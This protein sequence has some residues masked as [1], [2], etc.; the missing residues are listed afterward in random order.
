MPIPAAIAFCLLVAAF[1]PAS[2]AAGDRALPL[3]RVADIRR[4]SHGEAAKAL[5]VKVSGVCFWR[6]ARDLAIHDGEEGDWVGVGKALDTGLIAPG[7]VP[8]DIVPGDRLEIEGVTDPGGYAPII[9]PK[10]IRKAGRMP[11]P[12]ARR[13]PLEELLSGRADCQP[14]EVEGILQGH[15]RGGSEGGDPSS[16]AS[17]VVDGYYCRVPFTNLPVGELARMVDARIR[18][19][20]LF[21]P[22]ANSRAEGVALKVLANGR[23]SIE[24]VEP[25]LRDPFKA[26]RVSLDRLMPFSPD[27]R[28]FNRKV[29]AGT[30]VFAVPGSFFFI[31][32]AGTS[33]RVSSENARPQ[34]GDRVE[35][36]GFVD[37]YRT[38]ASLK[39]ALSRKI[40]TAPV[41]PAERVTVD[42][43]LDL[44][45][46]WEIWRRTQDWNGRAV[47]LDGV[48]RRVDWKEPMVP[49]AVWI[50]SGGQT[51]FANFPLPQKLTPAQA[52]RWLPGAEVS[53]QGVCELDFKSRSDQFGKFVPVGFHLWMS[54]P[55]DMQVL[56]LPPWLTPGRL[57]LLLAGSGIAIALLFLW[58]WL[59]RKQVDRQTRI[60][61]DK[62][63]VEAANAERARIARDIHDDLGAGLTE[64]AM[65]G[66]LALQEQARPEASARH[67]ERIFHASQEMTRS[68]DEIVWAVTPGNDSLDKL[69][70]FAGELAQS[71]LAGA[72]IRC[73]LDLPDEVP[74]HEVPA[75]TRHHLCMALK[76]AL[77]NIVKHSGAS[78]A[79]VR[80]AW[81]GSTFAMEISDNGTGFDPSANPA[82]DGL[83]D[84]LRNM[85]LRMEEIG[86]TC[87][88]ESAPGQGTRVRLAAKI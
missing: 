86:G 18:V 67:L 47:R 29:V 28:P 27:S 52:A 68:L 35:V 73:R 13:L 10:V 4:L 66:D 33:V 51:F 32:D 61:G 65:L 71:I 1:S 14:V 2:V 80:I 75:R 25:A 58:A 23:E 9:L 36:A 57:W 16:I 63:R 82:S 6:G 69:V 72:G 55:G 85:S 59:L 31:E 15:W 43:I 38:F 83:H 76:E 88:I 46:R 20:G 56:R 44:G 70:A 79:G 50:E 8:A 22:D 77:H 64:I 7:G 19:R 81:D 84:G 62:G 34:V 87:A 5:P 45:N 78:Q 3:T 21:T 74:A 60:I 40:G 24:V 54:G 37:T 53:V 26:P 17:M 42:Q 41:P 49:E 11:L 30:V 39:N 12:E 48:L